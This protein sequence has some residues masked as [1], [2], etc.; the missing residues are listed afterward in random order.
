MTKENRAEPSS[1]PQDA[2]AAAAQADQA[3]ANKSQSAANQSQAEGLSPSM[4]G[5]PGGE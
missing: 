3:E 2:K 5:D 1:E 4:G